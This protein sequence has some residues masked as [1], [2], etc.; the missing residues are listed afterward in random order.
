MKN[1]RGYLGE[2]L[3]DVLGRNVPAFEILVEMSEGDIIICGHGTSFS[4]LF[5]HL[6]DGVFGY[7]EFLEMKMPDVFEYEIGS[8]NIVKYL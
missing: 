3:N 8:N 7:D 2:S 6:T 5:N 4:V 1:I